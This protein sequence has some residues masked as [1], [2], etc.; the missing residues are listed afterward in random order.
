MEE[1]MKVKKKG[2]SK[3]NRKSREF[4]ADLYLLVVRTTLK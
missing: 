2:F 1:R 3:I 4:V